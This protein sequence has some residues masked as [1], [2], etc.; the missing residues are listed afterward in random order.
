[1]ASL[2]PTQE[3]NSN[4]L[5]KRLL[6]WS[7]FGILA[8]GAVV[9]GVFAS[10]T[11]G[12]VAIARIFNSLFALQ[13][14]QITWYITRAAGWMAYLLLWF[15]TV[16]GLA[17]PSKLID[18]ILPRTFTFDF[19]Q[20]ISLLALGFTG[21]HVAVLAFD[22]Y[23]PFSVGQMMIPFISAYR[24]FWV[25]IGI[26]ATY[27][28]VLVTVT[29]YLRKRI[30]MRAFR[31]IH[32]SSLLAYLGATVHGVMAGTDS[33]LPA[34]LWIYLGTFLVVVFLTAYWLIFGWLQKMSASKKASQVQIDK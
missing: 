27:L 8:I 6:L 19:H 14:T 15:S 13:S 18:S 3:P 9:L 17:I 12:G 34:A 1:M 29:F 11:G 4:N 26:L 25:G 23:A 32:L 33:P 5:L 28:M 22:H 21:V 2:N 7:I 30:G 10:L 20:F 31:L 24:P 16:W